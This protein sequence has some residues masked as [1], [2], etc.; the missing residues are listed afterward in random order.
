MKSA[1]EI[2]PGIEGEMARWDARSID[3]VFRECAA[4]HSARIAIHS[5]DEALSYAELDAGIDRIAAILDSRRRD[6]TQN[7]ALLFDQGI[8]AITAIFGALRC[9]LTYIPLDSAD[10]AARI[11]YILDDSQ[12]RLIV[13][14]AAHAEMAERLTGGSREI[15]VLDRA[16]AAP[17]GGFAPRKIS[18]DSLAYIFYTSGSTGQP[19]GVMQTHRNLLHF[20]WSYSQRLGIAPGDRLSFLYTLSFS[21]AN[22][23]IYGGLLRGAALCPYD[24]RRRGTAGLAQWMIDQQISVL[25][26]VPTLY[27]H[28]LEGAAPGFVFDKVR[29]VDL[30]GE[31]VFG[32]DLKLL[33]EHFRPDCVLVNHLA[34]TEASVIA[35]ETF[36]AGATS[37]AEG[38]LPA[39]KA[40][41]GMEIRIVGENGEELPPGQTGEI[42]IAS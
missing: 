1:G 42:V 25:H 16:Q 14:D 32:S 41:P 17:A 40:A 9:G 33:R 34:A 37:A 6:G 21:A 10:P 4:K 19:K 27:R 2:D 28:L 5:V 31:A 15:A 39:G 26:T 30:G 38:A 24:L 36:L 20:A 23:D 11:E 29:A 35:Q 13:T 18:P 3:E 12:S 7:V 8:E 22:M